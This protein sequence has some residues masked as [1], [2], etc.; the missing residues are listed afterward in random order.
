[1]ILYTFLDGAI[2]FQRRGLAYHECSF[3]YNRERKKISNTLNG[4]PKLIKNF[5]HDW[6]NKMTSP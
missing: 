3:K 6:S 1:M 2:V 4:A 5:F